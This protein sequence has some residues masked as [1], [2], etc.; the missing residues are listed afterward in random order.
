MSKSNKTIY[1]RK[2][3]RQKLRDHFKVSETCL[4]EALNFHIHSV[5][6]RKIRCY[7]M[8]VCSGMF[9]G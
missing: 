5:T 6:A 7:A 8:N 4:S 3:D 9:F 1:L 2:D